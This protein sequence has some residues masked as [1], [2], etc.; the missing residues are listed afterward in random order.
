MLNLPLACVDILHLSVHPSH[1]LCRCCRPLCTLCLLVLFTRTSL[2]AATN[3][4]VARARDVFQSIK[5]FRVRVCCV[6]NKKPVPSGRDKTTAKTRF[7]SQSLTAGGLRGCTSTNNFDSRRITTQNHKTKLEVRRE[8]R[9]SAY[10]VLHAPCRRLLCPQ[11]LHAFCL[12]YMR[13]N[14]RS[15]VRPANTRDENGNQSVENM[16][17]SIITTIL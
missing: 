2:Q 6:L 9:R 14:A 1:L 8:K 5:K 3:R 10:C 7:H 15:S 11:K 16:H 17:Y 13:E 4:K 12:P